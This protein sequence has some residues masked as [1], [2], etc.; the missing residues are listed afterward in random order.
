M[1]TVEAAQKVVGVGAAFGGVALYASG[2]Q[3]AIGITA[4]T[5][6][7]NHMVKATSAAIETAE[8]VETAAAV[9]V[10]DGAAISR[11]LEKIDLFEVSGVMR[12]FRATSEWGGIGR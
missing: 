4:A 8:A 3:V 1:F 11:V 10:V 5:G 6:A 9:A 12:W 7:R 2:D